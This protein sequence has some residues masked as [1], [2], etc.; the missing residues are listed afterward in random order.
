MKSHGIF[1]SIAQLC[2]VSLVTIPALTLVSCSDDSGTNENHFVDTGVCEDECAPGERTCVTG[3]YRPCG[4][5][6]DDD[7]YEWG[8]VVPCNDGEECIDGE[9]E[10][11][12]LLNE[13]QEGAVMCSADGTGIRNC[14]YMDN[15][16]IWVWG[17]VELCGTDK[18][19]SCGRCRIN[20]LDECVAGST[21]CFGNGYQ[22][23]GNHDSDSCLEWGPTNPCTSDQTCSNGSCSSQCTNECTADSVQCT[24]AGTMVQICGNFD[25][26]PCLEWSTAV[27]CPLGETCSSGICSESCTNEC[28]TPG[29][30]DCNSS[31]TGFVECDDHNEN[32]C[33]EWGPV[34]ECPEGETCK[35][36]ECGEYCTCDNEQGI[37]E[38]DSPHTTDPCT[39]DPDCGTPCT[40]DGYCDPWCTPGEDPDCG[41]NCDFTAY[42]E[43]QSMDSTDTCPCDVDC[44][45]HDYACSDDGYCDPWCP[46]GSDPD[47]GEDPCRPRYMLV[48][49][50]NADETDL[51]GQYTN[52]CPEEGAPWVLLS[53]GNSSGESSF[54]V[55]F[56][57]DHVDCVTE[58]K[59][60]VWGYDDSWTGSGAEMQLYDWNNEQYDVLPDEKIGS[61]KAWY[62]NSAYNPLPYLYCTTG[63]YAKCYIQFKLRAAWND[64]THFW[65]AYVDVYMTN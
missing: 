63:Q 34:N 32:G 6:D 9:C 16:G 27:P 49:Y 18:T 29:M 14:I 11:K 33:L 10:T 36:G 12:A 43:A 61:D 62:N 23:C 48:G 57:K 60:K 3:G 64:N 13:C 45:L 58:I 50:R 42:C 47:C 35:D 55:S 26:D 5:F 22:T 54:M 56:P 46:E 15:P 19:C 41:C 28:E 39:C 1:R 65:D 40:A 21:R 38:V 52:P 24:C 7:C 8:P 4:D 30:T 25:E 53:P 51:S 17:E 44:D 59:V 31:G 20:C 2:F 37:C